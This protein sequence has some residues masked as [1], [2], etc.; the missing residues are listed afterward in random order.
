VKTT[1]VHRETVLAILLIWFGIYP[2]P[3]LDVIGLSCSRYG[4][5]NTQGALK[6]SGCDLPH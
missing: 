2:T 6:V 5:E 4:I 1:G 3:L